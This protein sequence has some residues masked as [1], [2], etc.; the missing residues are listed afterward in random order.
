MMTTMRM[1][2]IAA[3]GVLM[4]VIMM[5]I[6]IMMM[7]WQWR[8][9][10]TVMEVMVQYFQIPIRPGNSGQNIYSHCVD[11]PLT[12]FIFPIYFLVSC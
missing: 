7:T 11:V 12:P 10:S 6:L 2:M 1:M 5:T 8:P 3:L 4:M 9:M